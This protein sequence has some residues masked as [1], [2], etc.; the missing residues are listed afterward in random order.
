MAY[1][2]YSSHSKELQLHPLLAT[3]NGL[4]VLAKLTIFVTHFPFLSL[5][6]LFFAKLTENVS[7]EIRDL[8]EFN[9][10]FRILKLAKI[11]FDKW[12]AM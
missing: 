11:T 8:M 12:H 6:L 4:S 7:S 1:N 3:E 5:A 10:H 9:R 2:Q